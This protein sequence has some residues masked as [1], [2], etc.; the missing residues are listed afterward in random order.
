MIFR[1]LDK[2]SRD[3]LYNQNMECD[4]PIV[5][6]KTRKRGLVVAVK[7]EETCERTREGLNYATVAFNVPDISCDALILRDN[8]P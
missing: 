7:H 4:Q 5:K 1:K 2:T 6:K 8:P 3:R